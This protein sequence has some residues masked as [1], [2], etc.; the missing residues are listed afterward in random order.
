MQVTLN[1]GNRIELTV[2]GQINAAMMQSGLD[3]LLELTAPLDHFTYLAVMTN[4]TWPTTGAIRAEFARLPELFRLMRKMNRA[5]VIANQSWLRKAAEVE[6]ALIPGLDIA[7]FQPDERDA[8][9]AF[10]AR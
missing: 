8:A 2:S 5:A 7:A 1:E 3:R 6:G 9:L 4:I 10:L